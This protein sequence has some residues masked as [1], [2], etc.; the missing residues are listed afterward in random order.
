MLMAKNFSHALHIVI[1]CALSY[2]TYFLFTAEQYSLAMMA[3]LITAG[4]SIIF[5][6][7]KFYKARFYYPA[8][9]GL[10]LFTV[11]PVAYTSYVGFTNYGGSNLL[12]FAQVQRYFSSQVVVN[13]STEQPYELYRNGEEYQ[14]Y[15]PSVSQLSSPFYLPSS[16][17]YDMQLS[18]PSGEK[19]TLRDIIKLR[20]ELKELQFA[21][22]DQKLKMSGMKTFAEVVPAYTL[23]DDSGTLRSHSGELLTPDHSKGYYVDSVGNEIKPGWKTW[24]GAKN[25][26]RI[27]ESDGVREP[28]F[29]IF[30]WTIVFAL[31]SVLGTFAIGMLLAL[32]LQWRELK[33]K[34]TLSNLVD[35]SLCCACLYI[36]T[37][38]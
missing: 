7:P 26:E 30:I 34:K 33:G 25:F 32:V 31:G 21:Y 4:F 8:I 18:S 11:F 38:V 22:G 28:I 36:D 17:E 10:V 12:T 13:K 2:V 23:V 9:A 24:I 29:A 15:L 1:A 6:S 37:S 27:I 5:F 19:V 14:L 3:V 20:G 35:T 16:G